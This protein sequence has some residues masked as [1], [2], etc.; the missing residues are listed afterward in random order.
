MTEQRRRLH[1]VVDA[2]IVVV[3]AALLFSP[4]GVV[5]RWITNVYDDRQERRNIA[6]VW[7]ELSEAESR[8]GSG[9]NQR[10]IVEFVDYECPSCR[11]VARSVSD[12]ATQGVTVVFRHFPLTQIH[13]VARDAAL[14]AICAERYGVF[15]Q[16]HE[17]M[18]TDDAW[19][20][21]QGWGSLD[22]QGGPA[23]DGDLE[24]CMAE[25]ETLQR[26]KRDRELAELLGVQGTPSFVT[27][28]GVFLGAD[29]WTQALATLPAD[30][31][32]STSASTSAFEL[33]ADTLF[34]SAAHPNVAISMLAKLSNAMFLAGGRLLIQDGVWF[35]FVDIQTGEVV[36]V[37]GNG[38]GPGEFETPL[39][40]VRSANGVVVW[41]VVLGRLTLLAETGKYIDSHRFDIG[42]LQSPMAPLVAAFADNSVVFRD[43]S[44]A[45]MGGAWPSGLHREPA[46]YVR[47]SPDGHSGLIHNAR[48]S[49]ILYREPM[50]APVLF[51]HSVLESP[52]G[53][54]LAVAQT[55]LPTIKVY[56]SNGNVLSRLPM[57][58][59]IDV[60]R[61]QVEAARNDAI[62]EEEGRISR[63]SKRLGYSLGNDLLSYDIPANDPAPPIDGM[64]ADL[65]NRRLWLRQYR[66]PEQDVVRWTAWTLLDAKIDVH[67]SIR[68]GEGSLLDANGD[69]ALLHIQDEFD[70]DR[71]LIRRIKPATTPEHL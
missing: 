47:F 23:E 65:D 6:E 61:S 39:Q 31:R 30:T 56:D 46:R 71:V 20:V 16:A 4:Q 8:I 32:E 69:L 43:D 13:P 26:L 57:P 63:L 49:E 17:A 11:S 18:L 60:S 37:G 48:G 19:M 7:S 50:N 53:D 34:D 41:D 29:G 35:H 55:D 38:A 1:W 51:A 36:T 15:A 2:A 45:A 21:G 10:T 3:L 54:A 9:S 33:S 14:V 52:L 66:L 70:V 59:P 5:G 28:E 62:A 68:R 42:Q 67:L 58:G 40:T 24:T 44:T 12:A 22:L 27:P 64:F 25:D